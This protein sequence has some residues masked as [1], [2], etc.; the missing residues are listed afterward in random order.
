MSHI[1]SGVG[2]KSGLKSSYFC[3]IITKKSVFKFIIIFVQ[4]SLNHTF[5][6]RNFLLQKIL[7]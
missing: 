1:M 6:Y 4:F 3:N 2:N 5:F 7:Q